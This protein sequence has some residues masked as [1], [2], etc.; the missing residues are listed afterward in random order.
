MKNSNINKIL[1]Y[2]TTHTT[3]DTVRRKFWS[4]LI[5][6]IDKEQKKDELFNIWEG[7][8]ACADEATHRSLNKVLRKVNIT[9]EKKSLYSKQIEWIMRASVIL[10][11]LLSIITSL[12]YIEHYKK[13]MQIVECSIPFGE[14]K[15]LTLPDGTN[16][17]VNSGSYLIYPK[18]F[19]GST[20]TVFL[21]GEANFNVC[22][23]EHHPFI[24]KTSQMSVQA[25]GTK[26]NVQAYSNLDKSIAILERGSVRVTAIENDQQSFILKPNEQIEYNHFTK[27]FEKRAVNARVATGWTQGELN[28]INCSLKDI[29]DAL[30]RHFNVEINVDFALKSSDLYTIKLKKGE[31]FPNAIQIVTLTVGGINAQFING[32]SVMLTLSNTA[33]KKGGGSI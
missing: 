4:W 12:I 21:S 27:V 23:D 13:D 29:L 10:I 19:R 1:H 18:Q 9:V 31:T 30:Q 20:R 11:P 17:T 26:F 32:N 33:I 25:L 7:V 14:K 2:F 28:F 22:K 16:V 8:D 5:S 24:V 15:E 6:P 3:S